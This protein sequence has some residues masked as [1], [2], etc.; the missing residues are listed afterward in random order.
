MPIDWTDIDIDNYKEFLKHP[1]FLGKV[2][3]AMLKLAEA[4]F[5]E[6]LP[7]QPT[8]EEI[9]AYAAKQKVAERFFENPSHWVYRVG[10]RLAPMPSIAQ[11]RDLI[12]LSNDELTAQQK[13]TVMDAIYAGLQQQLAY[14]AT[15][16]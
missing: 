1:S 2:E 7:P 8:Q 5:A 11:H 13:Q 4:L 10:I 15:K 16:V 14:F 3:T 12:L 6:T 9:A